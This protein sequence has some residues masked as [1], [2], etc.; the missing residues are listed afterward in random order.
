MALA[1]IAAGLA[2]TAAQAQP[3]A[4]SA[5]LA[6]PWTL[7]GASEGDPY[8]AV[9]L[10]R[11]EAIGGAAIEIS[12]TCRRNYDMEDIAAWALRGRDI[13]FIDALRK[14]RYVFHR[15]P[16]GTYIATQPRDLG[17]FLER[18]SPER[19]ASIRALFDDEGTFTLSG[20][21]NAKPCGF[22]VYGKGGLDQEGRCAAPW[23][24]KGWKR[25]SVKGNQLTLL[26]GK[27][28]VI[29]TLTRS[30]AYTFMAQTPGGPIFFGPGYI[31][32]SEMLETPTKP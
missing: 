30:D 10:G 22:A 26:D 6:G 7:A 27:G 8:C 1:A 31:D 29:L 18:G 17:A 14:V 24:G 11:G 2:V 13:V 20:P 21:N 5:A 25:W 32:G 23:K 3:A 19:P 4:W 9:T 15:S 16:D 12:A 28:G